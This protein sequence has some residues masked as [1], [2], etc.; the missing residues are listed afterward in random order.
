M[1]ISYD[2]EIAATLP[3]RQVA[4]ILDHAARE[5]GLL[6]VPVSAQEWMEK[7]VT[8]HRGTFVQVFEE[9]PQPWHPVITDLGFTPTV[10]VSFRLDKFTDVRAQQDDMIRAVDALLA[11][12]P[13]DALLEYQS[14]VIWLLRRTGVLDLSEDDELWPQDRLALVRRPYRRATHTFSED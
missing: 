4:E 6:D 9:H 8:T 10:S 13:G 7:G 14:E 11:A 3:A 12:I 1:A 5:A 2:F